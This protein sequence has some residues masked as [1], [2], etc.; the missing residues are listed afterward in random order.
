[1]GKF[2]LPPYVPFIKFDPNDV[3]VFVIYTLLKVALAW[4][5][6]ANKNIFLRFPKT[7]AYY[8]FRNNVNAFVMRIELEISN[9]KNTRGP[10]A[11]E[12]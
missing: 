11:R 10:P 8:Q 1:V 6:L 5:L 3:S 9:T 2:L 4:W 12:A 7:L